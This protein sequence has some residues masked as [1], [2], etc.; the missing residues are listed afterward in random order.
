MRAEE[1]ARARAEGSKSRMGGR[2]WHLW[3]TV[4]RTGSHCVIIVRPEAM[5]VKGITQG[6]CG[7]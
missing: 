4:S 6:A 7:E 2:T 1:G 3:E 5:P